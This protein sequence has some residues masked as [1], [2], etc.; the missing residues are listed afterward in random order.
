MDMAPP[1]TECIMAAHTV[2]RANKDMA[3]SVFN[4]DPEAPS[5]KLQPPWSSVKL[6]SDMRNDI[7]RALADLGVVTETNMRTIVK[8]C[9]TKW[10]SA[11][12]F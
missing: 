4:I 9:V 8:N 12:Q 5:Y 3:G 1:F 11:L 7:G 2:T 10:T 6:S